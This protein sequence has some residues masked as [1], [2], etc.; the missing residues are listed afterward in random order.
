MSKSKRGKRRERQRRR[1]VGA[2]PAAKGT[3][4]PQSKHGWE[5]R[6]KGSS[7]WILAW[8]KAHRPRIGGHHMSLYRNFGQ[9]AEIRPAKVDR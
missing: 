4:T 8:S 3:A 7:S 5:L 1:G 2:P 9:I 6:V